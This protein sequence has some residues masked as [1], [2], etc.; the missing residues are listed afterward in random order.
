MNFPPLVRINIRDSIDDNKYNK[1]SSVKRN[2]G[3]SQ[4]VVAMARA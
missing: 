4:N 3:C 2:F 1:L